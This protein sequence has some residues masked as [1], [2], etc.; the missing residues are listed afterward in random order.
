MAQELNKDAKAILKSWA[1]D[2]EAPGAL[3][4]TA[5]ARNTLDGIDWAL[6]AVEEGG[7]ANLEEALQIAAAA[8][9]RSKRFMDE[10]ISWLQDKLAATA[11]EG[12]PSPKRARR[13]VATSSGQHPVFQHGQEE[14]Q[15]KLG[16]DRAGAVQPEAPEPALPALR[17]LQRRHP[18]PQGVQNTE[19]EATPYQILRA[20]QMLEGILPFLEHDVATAVAEAHS[21][22]FQWTTAL[23]G[24]PV[25]LVESQAVGELSPNSTAE[26]IPWH[27]TEP[28]GAPHV[29]LE[30]T[31]VDAVTTGDEEEDEECSSQTSHRRRRLHAAFHDSLN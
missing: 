10:L 25:V 12:S 11:P 23:W 30:N 7:V 3:P 27:P 18:L 5:A 8:A 4:G 31:A 14:Q 20:Q 21:Y 13:E 17:E 28:G 1:S 26:T 9:K 22:L 15:G 19:G 16:Y 2:P 29:E 6:L 24:S